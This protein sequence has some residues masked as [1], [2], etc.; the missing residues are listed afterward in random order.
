MR[1]LPGQGLGRGV[2]V[3]VP[4]RRPAVMRHREP[5]SL[6]REGES[7]GG[8]GRLEH[9]FPALGIAG[10]HAL[11]RRERDPAVG[12]QGQGVDPGGTLRGRDRLGRAAGLDRDDP[13][14]VA[15]GDEA[16]AV[17]GRHQDPGLGMGLDPRGLA[18]LMDEQH[19]PVAEGQG[20]GPAEPVRRDDVGAGRH[21]GDLLGE[22]G[23]SGGA[24]RSSL[25]LWGVARAGGAGSPEPGG[26]G[27]SHGRAS[28]KG[29]RGV[30]GGSIAR[31]GRFPRA[32]TGRP[33]GLRLRSP[34][35]VNSMDPPR[36]RLRFRRFFPRTV[37]GPHLGRAGGP[38]P[39]GKRVAS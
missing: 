21:V 3:G 5:V 29:A 22:G 32:L 31:A 24:H 13:A 34:N 15:S 20:E 18:T 16:L 8:R 14:V 26:A 17:A 27:L 4:Q 19:R 12:M 23:G 2:E 11:A 39:P 35:P 9:L 7:A 38:Y 25:N 6:G 30:R 28:R 10:D 33:A 36:T 37:A 1:A